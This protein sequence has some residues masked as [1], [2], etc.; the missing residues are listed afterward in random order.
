MY[1]KL[2]QVT[3]TLRSLRGLVTATVTPNVMR[4]YATHFAIAYA[5]A[6]IGWLFYSHRTTPTSNDNSTIDEEVCKLRQ[7][8]IESTCNNNFITTEI[9]QNEHQNT[10]NILTAD[11]ITSNTVTKSVEEGNNGYLYWLGGFLMVMITAIPWD[12]SSIAIH[13]LIDTLCISTMIITTFKMM[14]LVYTLINQVFKWIVAPLINNF[15]GIIAT[16]TF[17]MAITG[18]LVVMSLELVSMREFRDG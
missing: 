7:G 11:N 9:N 15:F 10:S 6:I 13:T 4:G 18:F 3:Q 2:F 17:V 16:N 12:H 1:N 8:H 14:K 5:L